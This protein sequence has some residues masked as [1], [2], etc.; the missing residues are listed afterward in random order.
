MIFL[1]SLVSLE[2]EEQKKEATARSPSVLTKERAI[3]DFP[4]PGDPISQQMRSS[5]EAAVS[6]RAGD[7][8]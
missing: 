6:S 4:V 3:A 5:A 7:N 1:A 2:D 8:K